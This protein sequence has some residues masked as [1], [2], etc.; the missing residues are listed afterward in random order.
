MKETS[1]FKQVCCWARF[2]DTKLIKHMPHFLV[3]LLR[4]CFRKTACKAQ[5][6][7]FLALRNPLVASFSETHTP[8]SRKYVVEQG[9]PTPIWSK[10]SQTFWLHSSVFALEKQ[11]EKV[12]FQSFLPLRNPLVASFN[13]TRAPTSR[14]Y[15][16]E[17]GLAMSNWSKTF[18]TF[19]SHS[20]VFALEKEPEKVNFQSIFTSKK[21][22][23]G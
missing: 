14:K 20:C 9:L 12:N 17:K 7:V 22:F 13:E 1:F 2:T 19:W 11:P 23:G 10:T 6:S 3:A 15:V 18:E 16:V 21:P 4:F 5:F 8:T